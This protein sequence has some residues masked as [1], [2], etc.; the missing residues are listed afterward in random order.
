MRLFL[1]IIAVGALAA[2]GA[3]EQRPTTLPTT[4]S[5]SPLA[6][7][8]ETLFRPPAEPGCYSTNE[9]ARHLVEL[10]LGSGEARYFHRDI[11]TGE[12]TGNLGVRR[13]VT[14]LR[15]SP[16]ERNRTGVIE[17]ATGRTLTVRWRNRTRDTFVF[18][19]DRALGEFLGRIVGPRRVLE[20]ELLRTAVIAYVRSC[21]VAHNGR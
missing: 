5:S 1:L 13:V 15:L 16:T 14:T 2:C 19:T 3:P 7:A 20:Q 18:P 12:W 17:R 6:E 21:A 11:A 4:I 8:Q 9:Q 10:A